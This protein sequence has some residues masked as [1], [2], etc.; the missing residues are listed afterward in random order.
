M[1]TSIIILCGVGFVAGVILA[2]SSRVFYVEEDP[3][4]EAVMDVLPGAN[5][6]GCGYPGCEGYAIAVVKNTEVGA[7]L[8]VAGDDKTTMNVGSLTGKAVTELDPLV[9]VRRCEKLE[10]AVLTRFSYRGVPSCASA[11]SLGSGLGVDACPYSCLGLGDCVQVCPFD[12]LTLEDNIVKVNGV[13]CI[14]C[15]KCIQACPRHLLEIIPKNSRVMVFCST[16]QKPKEVKE[17]C[18][19]GC[20]SCTI[21]V[22]KCPAKAIIMKNKIIQIDHVACR[23]YGASCEQICATSCPRKILKTLC[24]TDCGTEKEDTPNSDLTS[25]QQSIQKSDENVIHPTT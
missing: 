13:R 24:G 6:G 10:G 2:I 12:A 23:E 21:C 22:K 1:L 4:V 14:G 25:I 3:R 18:K 16:E 19:V 5:C 7:N 15:G 17:V 11:A 9:S 20:I 8:C